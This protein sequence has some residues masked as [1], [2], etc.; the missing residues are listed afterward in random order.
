[1]FFCHRDATHPSMFSLHFLTELLCHCFDKLPFPPCGAGTS[2]ISTWDQRNSLYP[3]VFSQRCFATAAET[4]MSKHRLRS[5]LWKTDWII[6]RQPPRQSQQLVSVCLV[7]AEQHPVTLHLFFLLVLTLTGFTLMTG[8]MCH[9][10]LGNCLKP[11]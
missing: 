8:M 11:H 6:H 3:E 1:M 7:A 4:S 2:S 10:R 9:C 5:A